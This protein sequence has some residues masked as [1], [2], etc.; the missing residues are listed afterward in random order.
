METPSVPKMEEDTRDQQPEQEEKPAA[1]TASRSTSSGFL[2]LILL[3]LIIGLPLGWFL[4]PEG[5]RQS[6]TGM[7]TGHPP[8]QSPGKADISSAPVQPLASRPAP[9]P[10]V[11]RK[12]AAPSA[13][14]VRRPAAP[15]AA[16]PPPL[17][18]SRKPV[19]H[20]AATTEEVKAL[21]TAMDGLRE[22]METLRNTQAELRRELQARQRLELRDYLRLIAGPESQ[23]PRMASLWRDIALLPILSADERTE[24]EGMWKLAG[25]NAKKLAGWI[26]RLKRL[27]G[28]LPEAEHKDMIPKPHNP[29]FSWLTGKFHLRHAPASEQRKLSALRNRLLTT[30]HALAVEIW[31]EHKAWRHLLTDLREHFGDDADLGLP[32]H[33]DGIRKD[34]AGMRAKAADWL[35]S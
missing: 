18:A 6:W 10:S 27:A 20:P 4:I 5:T 29:A 7:L 12:S 25:A 11:T 8:Q 22:D 31:P 33:L 3:L 30:A 32:E 9:P 28:T 19:P 35:N 26:G 17:S 21:M 24:A 1:K 14:A 16:E 2:W 13:T 34:A 23:L 15:R